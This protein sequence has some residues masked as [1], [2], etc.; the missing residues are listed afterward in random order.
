M[1]NYLGKL[2]SLDQ[3]YTVWFHN[4]QYPTHGGSR[5]ILR[6]EGGF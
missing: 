4:Y 6:G 1:V 5:E 2:H 3:K